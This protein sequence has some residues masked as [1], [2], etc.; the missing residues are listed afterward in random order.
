MK[1]MMLD[2]V[3]VY[4]KDYGIERFIKRMNA[5]IVIG[6]LLLFAWFPFRLLCREVFGYCSMV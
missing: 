2:G 1:K 3:V 4:S 6:L 5:V